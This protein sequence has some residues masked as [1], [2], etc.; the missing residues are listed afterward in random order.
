MAME[1]FMS[2]EHDTSIEVLP[3]SSAQRRLW[4]LEQIESGG[5]A[6]IT[7]VV[8]RM[9]GP[10][11]IGVLERSLGE[12]MERHEVTRATFEL[13]DDGNPGQVI[14]PYVGYKLPF[15][16]LTRTATPCDAADEARRW[17]ER[18]WR[19]PFDIAKG[20]LIRFTLLRIL[21]DEHHLVVDTHHLIADA[22]SLGI[23]YHELRALYGSRIGGLDGP[24]LP[25]LPIQYGDFAVWENTWLAEAEGEMQRSLAAWRERL[26]DVPAPSV[27]PA[28]RPRTAEGP[29]QGKTSLTKLS[30]ELMVDL[31]RLARE[32]G[33]S[34][35]MVL[36]A[37]F[38]VLL[39]RYSGE[40]DLVI[41]SAVAGRSHAD[42]EGLI[43][44]FVNP[45]VF[46]TDVSGAPTFRDLLG[47][48]KQTVLDAYEHQQVPFDRLVEEL[49]PERRSAKQP[50]FQTLLQYTNVSVEADRL[51]D[52]DIDMVGFSSEAPGIDLAVTVVDEAAGL[53][54]T[55]EFNAR[56]F[57]TAT[58]ERMQ[59]HFRTLLESAVAN[60]DASIQAMRMMTGDEVGRLTA[61]GPE[62]VGESAVPARLHR[63]VEAHAC[64]APTATALVSSSGQVSYQELDTHAN[65]LARAL[66]AEG[67]GPESIVG[68]C[69]PRGLDLPLVLL[70]IL[71]A[72]GGYLPLDP[73]YPRERLAFMAEDS[74]ARLVVTDQADDDPTQAVWPVPT[75]SLARLKDL[76]AG[77]SAE[78]LT[79]ADRTD[80]IAYVVYTS[81][82]TG[83]PKGVQVQHDGLANV[84]RAQSELFGLT[85][86]DRVGQFFSPS[87]DASVFEITMAFSAGAA[88]VVADAQD[89]LPGE[90]LA[91]TFR[92]C[93][94]TAVTM[95][96]SALMALGE[97]EIPSLRVISAAGEACPKTALRHWLAQ[98]R[99]FN[100]YGPTEATIWT[101]V[102]E[103]A[104][105]ESEP[106]P[107]LPIGRP[108][109]AIRAY[110]LN[111][112]LAPVPEL[113]IG[114]LYV[115]GTGVARGYLGRPGLTAERF[116]PDP[117]CPSPGR[118]M[119]RTG[120]LVRRR[121]DG[122]L[123]FLNRSDDQVKIRGYRVELGEV[124]EVLVESPRVRQCA[125]VA[126]ST[127]TG[128]NR[129]VCYVVPAGTGDRDAVKEI[130]AYLAERLPG[131]LIPD[132]VVLRDDLP[133][134]P[135]G[136]VDR[137]A[138]AASAAE[139]ERTTVP[140]LAPH[141][142]ME[143]FV[144]EVWQNLLR[145]KRVGVNDDF[146]DLGGHSLAATLVVTRLRADL[147]LEVP[148]TLLFEHRVLADY[149]RAVL[150]LAG[151]N[152]E[153]VGPA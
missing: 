65:R 106:G 117:F 107:M 150:D 38:N 84:A 119:Y 66:H 21:P 31:D 114:E 76:A 109:P 54:V 17:A 118:R 47:R 140:Y 42:V 77:L 79:A 57:E 12:V 43:G 128:A 98:A 101:T 19:Q 3:V 145:V 92:D 39:A 78:V 100:L 112:S 111:E 137:T 151:T 148:V 58:I 62:P 124:E 130:Q 133:R 48:V 55:W 143:E 18:Q 22:W 5:T 103:V 69:L 104:S 93:G 141:T 142:P 13:G 75:M 29:A 51:G 102:Q 28:D 37:A 49:R 108:I 120:D 1:S 96:P 63:L 64:S 116:L 15:V 70:A 20:P 97:V 34:L 136:K 125:A 149:S 88:L 121:S 36:L 73:E 30:P 40:E 123:E 147:G 86:G 138:L 83:T 90:M 6:W 71:K 82:S 131:Y 46:R 10:L 115:S 16:D 74:A 56:L 11:D 60:P 146:F 134:M 52:I 45:I 25:E 122:R 33:A 24:V 89:V 135:S 113:V 44:C 32:N 2:H 80:G 8:F 85:R 144:A 91:T 53:T 95:T 23:I 94:V 4:F 26:S 72:G 50:F 14:W 68:V 27:F 152:A 127:E 105:E 99:C 139:S 153:L 110:V 67:V 41:G 81:G 129:L 87:F 59:R 61:S 7:Q 126:E 9:R 132:A 35:F